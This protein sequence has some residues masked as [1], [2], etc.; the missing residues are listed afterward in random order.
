MLRW[1]LVELGEFE[2][3]M[4]YDLLVPIHDAIL[5]QCF[6]DRVEEVL[7]FVRGVM[8]RKWP[9]LGGLSIQVSVK[10]GLSW[11]EMEEVN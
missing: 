11:G 2:E 8:E 7:S 4:G 9:E 3:S 5:L 10:K 1:V 6:P